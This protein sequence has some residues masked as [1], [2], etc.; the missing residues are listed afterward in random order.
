MGRQEPG[1]FP[2]RSRESDRAMQVNSGQAEGQGAAPG[3][4]V[5]WQSCA[6]EKGAGGQGASPKV[7]GELAELCT[8][9]GAGLKV[10]GQ[11]AAPRG[12][13]KLAELCR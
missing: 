11:G 8:W 10:G 12:L 1:S 6:S 9:A 2:G 13:R 5:S 3:G 4:L 7:C